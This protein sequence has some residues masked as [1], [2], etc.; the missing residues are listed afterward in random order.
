MR[1]NSRASLTTATFPARIRSH[2]TKDDRRFEFAWELVAFVAQPSFVLFSEFGCIEFC[3]ESRSIQ[4][5]SANQ[6][7]V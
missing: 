6:R 5:K 1:I 4:V 7:C 3:Q 2:V